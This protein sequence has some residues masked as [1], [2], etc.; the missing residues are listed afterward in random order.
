MRLFRLRGKNLFDPGI[1]WGFEV[2]AFALKI[3]ELRLTTMIF[4]H[5]ME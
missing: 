3:A 5:I 2:N 4:F 1:S